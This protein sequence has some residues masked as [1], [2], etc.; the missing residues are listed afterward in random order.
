MCPASTSLL[1]PPPPLA[2]T[3]KAWVIVPLFVTSKAYVPGLGTVIVLGLREY[4]FSEIWIVWA[5][6]PPDALPS[7]PLPGLLVLLAPPQAASSRTAGTRIRRPRT[8]GVTPGNA[9]RIR[10]YR[11]PLT[12]PVAQLVRAADS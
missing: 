9:V 3:L 6:A 10:L 8:S 1:S 2:S 11:V 4:S 12:G 5:T 7:L